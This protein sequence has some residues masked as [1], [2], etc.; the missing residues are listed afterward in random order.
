MFVLN[1]CRTFIYLIKSQS[2]NE[3]F[4]SSYL[5]DV[6]LSPAFWFVDS[7]LGLIG[8]CFIF[9]VLFLTL[10]VVLFAYRVGIPYYWSISPTYCT[11]LVLIGHW[12]LINV[13][14]NY[15]MAVTTNPG[16]PSAKYDVRFP[17][18]IM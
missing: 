7:C 15:F 9:A 18:K 17:L 16:Y 6:L 5:L 11:I 2:Y 8:P 3:F 1:E 4:D 13:I 10:L 14:F 12:I